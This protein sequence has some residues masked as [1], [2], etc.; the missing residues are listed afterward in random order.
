MLLAP[1]IAFA[2]CPVGQTSA[3]CALHDEGVTAF[4]AGRYDEAATK[5]RAAIAA[6]P[7]ARSYLGYSQSV[8]GRGKIALAYET[9]LVAQ[10]LSNEELAAPGG[11]HDP[12]LVG[13][14]ERIKYKLAELGAKIAYVWLRLPEGIPI[15]RLVAVFR[16]GEGDLQ[17]PIGR[18]IVVAP[19]RQVLFATLDDGKRLQVIAQVAPGSQSSVVIPVPAMQMQPA[20]MQPVQPSQV[21]YQPVSPNTVDLQPSRPPPNPANTVFAIDAAFILGNS[22]GIGP[23]LG[24]AAMF[25]K[26]LTK[27]IAITGRGALVFHPSRDEEDLADT[28]TV[29]ANEGM[30]LVGARTRS[31]LPLYLSFETG[32]L[33]FNRR[34]TLSMT[35]IEDTYANTYLGVMFGGGVR[36]GKVHFETYMLAVANNGDY[37]MPV[38]F[39]ATFGVDLYR[40]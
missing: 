13:R 12:A 3:S 22:E 7:T 40:R 18:W 31:K 25:E 9:M 26:K 6:G 23:G 10:K 21:T 29:S 15:R 38:R 8:E 14:A 34:E 30:L 36:I 2:D 28:R 19:E 24:F 17:Q 16:E 33:F 20:Q 35:G 27:R 5:F 37:D 11:K 1:G 39:F 4:T 32:A